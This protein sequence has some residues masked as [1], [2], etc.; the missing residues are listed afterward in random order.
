[1]GMDKIILVWNTKGL[2][3][4]EIFNSNPKEGNSKEDIALSRIKQLIEEDSDIDYR[5]FSGTEKYTIK[6]VNVSVEF[7]NKILNDT[8]NV[9]I[10]DSLEETR[11]LN[12]NF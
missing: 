11:K 10:N 7:T 8:I 6:K 4:H 1:M 3:Y 5:V 9:I 2:S 12:K